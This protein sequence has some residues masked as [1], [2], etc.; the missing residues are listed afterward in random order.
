[1]QRLRRFLK[2]H[3]SRIRTPEARSFE[4]EG[5]AIEFGFRR[6][7]ESPDAVVRSLTRAA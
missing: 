7:L 6:T 3:G 2:E 1:V 5:E 4:T